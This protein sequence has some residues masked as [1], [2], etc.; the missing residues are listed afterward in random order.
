MKIYTR[1]GD[2]GTT[3]LFSGKRVKKSELF[4]EAVGTI[5]ECNSFIGFAL[6]L[7]S[8]EQELNR[9]KK[10]LSIIQHTLFDLG[11]HVATPLLE[12]SKEKIKRTRF[13]EQGVHEM[14]GWIDEYQELLPP[15]RHFIL[16]GGDSAGAAL[17]LARSICRR[18]ERILVG[19][20]DQKEISKEALMYINRLSDYLFVLARYVNAVTHTPEIE[21]KPHSHA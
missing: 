12:S 2:D 14:E 11:A 4:I 13:D 19:L 3:S 6:S 7:M 17:H 20:Y 9:V 21:W 1:T 15:L 18:G 10:E 16:P 8:L 5:D